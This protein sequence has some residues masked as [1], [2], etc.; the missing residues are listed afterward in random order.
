MAKVLSLVE[1]KARVD[2]EKAAKAK[3]ERLDRRN[4]N[5]RADRSVVRMLEYALADAYEGKFESVAIAAVV[6]GRER[7]L[8]SWSTMPAQRALAQYGAI[9]KLADDYYHEMNG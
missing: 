7:C 6:R 4:L 2:G 1:R 9:H 3:R 5:R 8:T